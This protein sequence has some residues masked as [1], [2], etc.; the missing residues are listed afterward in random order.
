MVSALLTPH[1]GEE[2][3]ICELCSLSLLLWGTSMRSDLRSELELSV[4]MAEQREFCL[5]SCQQSPSAGHGLLLWHSGM[6]Q[7]AVSSKQAAVLAWEVWQ[8][9]LAHP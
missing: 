8:L 4:A 9:Q 1:I 2:T 5:L 3:E 6:T 7:P